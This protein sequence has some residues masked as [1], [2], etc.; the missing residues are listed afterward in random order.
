MAKHRVVVI[1]GGL[2]GLSAAMKMAELDIP[3]D[4]VSLV[5]A[6]RSHSVCAQG[7]INS[8]NQVTRQLGDSEW[9]H[10]DDT[11]YGGDFLNAQPPAREMC[12]WAPRVVDL[13]DRIGVTFNRLPEGDRDVRRF[14]GTLYPRT[15]F[16]GATTGQQML[17]GLDEQVRRWEAAGLIARHEFCDFLG[18]VLDDKG[19]CRGA[20]IQDLYSMKIRALPA[21]AVMIASGGLGMIFGKSTNSTIC[22]GSAAARVYRAGVKYGNPEFIQV[23]PT[24]IPGTD[25][26]RLM[27]ESARGEGG[28]VWVPRKKGDTRKPAEIPEQER[29]YFLEEKYPTYGNLVPRDIAT[30]EI[31][32]VCRE[33]YSVSPVHLAAYLDLT[34]LPAE[35]I[36][37]LE[38]ILEIYEK[39]IGVDPRKSPMMVFPAVHYSMGGLWCDYEKDPRTGGLVIGSPRNQVTNIPGLYALGEA[40]YQYHG[41][42]RLGA[43]SLLSCIFAGLVAAEG[44]PAWLRNLPAGADAGQTGLLDAEV[45]RHQQQYD[46]LLKMDGKVNPFALHLELG[47]KMTRYCTVVRDNNELKQ[48]M[49]DLADMTER[50]TQIGLPDTGSWTNQTVRFVR[51]LNDMLVLARAIAQGALQRD[52]CRGAHYKPAFAIPSPTADDP[53]ELLRQAEQYCR[54]FATQA[55]RWLKTT[56]AVYTPNGPKMSYEPIDTSLIPPRPRTYGLKGAGII[57]RVWRDMQGGKAVVG[58]R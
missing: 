52:E 2:A 9:K 34:H 24:A 37:K 19:V 8:V 25:K 21:A 55:D 7:G 44:M 56:I 3:V 18:P 35:R 57:E 47:T 39:F 50:Y 33:G 49:S 45:R 29:W 30:R 43:N 51:E 12:Y 4:I 31:F 48:L 58:S 17:Y 28:R 32:W 16:A 42:N 27:S 1:G 13:L 5:P 38:G 20:I 26:H 54:T 11:V 10:L 40:D 36:E 46:Q 41:A 15:A 22:T 23:H 53:A 14:G 6:R